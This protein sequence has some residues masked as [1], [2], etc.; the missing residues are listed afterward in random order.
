MTAQK[1]ENTVS[2]NLVSKHC[3]ILNH[4]EE[5]KNDIWIHYNIVLLKNSKCVLAEIKLKHLSLCAGPAVLCQT[6]PA[7]FW[8][9]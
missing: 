1:K 8:T 7:R 3:L 5:E 4:L 2:L 6:S 9:T